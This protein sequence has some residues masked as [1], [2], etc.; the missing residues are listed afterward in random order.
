[1]PDYFL[2]NLRAQYQRNLHE[3]YFLEI[4]NITD[5]DYQ[6]WLGFPQPGVSI[7]GGMEYRH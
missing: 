1:M 4:R 7:Y 6:T 3:N 2:A 5:E